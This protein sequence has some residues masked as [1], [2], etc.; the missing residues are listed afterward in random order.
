MG[1]HKTLESC[2]RDLLLKKTDRDQ[3]H[4]RQIDLIFVTCIVIHITEL[5]PVCKVEPNLENKD[6]GN[7]MALLILYGIMWL[8]VVEE[9]DQISI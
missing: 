8:V 5:M 4:G 9:L 6:G 2:G 1:R 3:C 7:G